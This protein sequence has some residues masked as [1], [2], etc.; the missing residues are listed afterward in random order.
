[1]VKKK[2][3]GSTGSKYSKVQ[4]MRL[5]DIFEKHDLDR[6]GEQ[7]YIYIF[8]PALSSSSSSAPTGG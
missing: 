7:I 1:M 5:K 8:S 2:S 3:L 4:V 6:S